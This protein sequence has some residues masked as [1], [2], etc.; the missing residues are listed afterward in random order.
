MLQEVD[1][2]AVGPRIRQIRGKRTQKAFAALMDATQSYISDLERGKCFPSVA[3]LA[4]IRAVSGK[5]F[6][7][8]LTGKEVAAAPPENGEADYIEMQS[9]FGK[10]EDAS[11]PEKPQLAKMLIVSLLHVM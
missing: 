1:R 2:R 8:I 4:R 9:L 3:L 6:D 11:A 7:W 10:L 5:S